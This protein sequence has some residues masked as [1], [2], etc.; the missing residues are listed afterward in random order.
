M[1]RE[2]F[3][4]AAREIE[5][6]ICVMP[7]TMGGLILDLMKQRE[8]M[9]KHVIDKFNLSISGYHKRSGSLPRDESSNYRHPHGEAEDPVH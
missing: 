9:P 5:K 7:L 8:T 4:G 3:A 6:L 1:A 2:T